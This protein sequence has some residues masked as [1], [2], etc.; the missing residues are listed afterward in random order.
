MKNILS[1]FL[2]LLPFI[3]SAQTDT[4]I[5]KIVTEQPRFPG[6]EKLDTTIDVK[7]KCAE[8]ALLQFF[9]GNI[10][11][12]FEARQKDIQGTVVLSMVVEPDGLIS[13]PKVMRDIGGGCGDEALRVA[14]G[15][16]QAMREN[17]LR[18]KPGIK[19]GKEVRTEITV[20]I[21]FRLAEPEDYV[22]AD[23]RDT[24]YVV[25]DDSVSYKGGI[26]A[27]TKA[28]KDNMKV[29]A[30][31]QD[32]CV[33]GVIDMSLYVHPSGYVRVIELTDYWHMGSDYKWEAIRAATSTWGQWNPAKREGREVPA[34][35]QL[36]MP[37]LPEGAQCQQVVSNFE[38]AN[39]LAD[40]GSLLF[41]EGKQEE[42]IAKITEAIS[43]FPE[44]ANFLYLRG[45]AYMGMDKNDEACADFQR[46]REIATIGLVENI[47]PLLCGM[48]APVTDE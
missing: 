29:P 31:Y 9:M 41:N 28:L 20:P 36:S 3:L 47:L 13:N 46:I 25:L 24:M 39:L 34:S 14:N 30:G 17:Y 35:I 40:E 21:K 33:A 37:I 10:N 18:W 15:M 22:F 27:L 7:N 1:T 26:E 4:T 6:C 19:D 45:Q 11:Y 48:T 32:S 44:N 16:N 5:Y 12:P 2:L 23:G 42:G 38:K 8:R 43:L